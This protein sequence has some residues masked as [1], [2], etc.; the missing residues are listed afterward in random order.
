M[1]VSFS[2]CPVIDNESRHNIV[3]VGMDP[4]GN[5]RIFK[6]IC[7]WELLGGNVLNLH[8]RAQNEP[9]TNYGRLCALVSNLL[10]QMTNSNDQACA[11]RI[12]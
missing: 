9:V 7:A 10:S 8:A 12:K 2:C 11:E 3:K 6:K 1:D 5:S 4:Q